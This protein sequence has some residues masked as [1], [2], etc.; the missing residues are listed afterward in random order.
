MRLQAKW[1]L[2]LSQDVSYRPAT[3]NGCSRAR[4]ETDTPGHQQSLCT[5][6][7]LIAQWPVTVTQPTGDQAVIA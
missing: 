3:P 2:A 6:F 5:L 4:F 7:R 1:A